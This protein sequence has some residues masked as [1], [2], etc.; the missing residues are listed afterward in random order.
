M[1]QQNQTTEK[2]IEALLIS[3]EKTKMLPETTPPEA[4]FKAH[5]L[6]SARS[7]LTQIIKSLKPSF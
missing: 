7:V 4:F 1:T 5:M 2:R 3:I 6:A